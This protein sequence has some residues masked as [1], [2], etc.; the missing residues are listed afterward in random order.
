[1]KTPFS[2]SKLFG[3][4]PITDF[5]L[6]PL[7]L[8]FCFVDSMNSQPCDFYNPCRELTGPEFPDETTLCEQVTGFNPY[9]TIANGAYASTLHLTTWDASTTAFYGKDILIQGIFYIDQPT[10]FM[11]CR[12]K[13]AA[14]AQIVVL[15]QLFLTNEFLA[16]HCKFFSCDD[17]WKGIVLHYN[18]RCRLYSNRIEDAQYAITVYP[19]VYMA[20][21]GNTFNRNFVS[22]TNADGNHSLPLNLF[23]NNTFDCTSELSDYY[24][25]NFTCCVEDPV[26]FAGILLNNCSSKIGYYG[27]RNRFN[28]LNY[29]VFANNST[30]HINGCTFKD[31]Q[32]GTIIP[33]LI[34]EFPQEGSGIVG[35]NSNI[36]IIGAE[37]NTS[38]NFIDADLRALGSNLS[39]SFAEFEDCS[40]VADNN[41]VG[42]LVKIEDNKLNAVE[43]ESSIF[44]TR[45]AS[46]GG[47]IHT[48]IRRNI[49]D[50][51][52]G[53]GIGFPLYGIRLKGDYNPTDYALVDYNNISLQSRQDFYSIYFTVNK[54]E[55]TFIENN[56]IEFKG[57]DVDEGNGIFLEGGQTMGT[58]VAENTITG[59]ASSNFLSGI[60]VHNVQGMDIKDVRGIEY[61]QNTSDLLKNG[62][63]FRG[64]CDGSH[65]TKNI[66][67]EHDT[68][69]TISN[70]SGT[71]GVIGVQ[72]RTLNEWYGDSENG[73]Y[74]NKA[75]LYS[76]D[77]LLIGKSLYLLT[78]EAASSLV[79]NPTNV[80]PANGWFIPQPG[81]ENLC[82]A[83]PGPN[84]T[85]FDSLILTSNSLFE[86]LP[87]PVKFYL[88][89]NIIAK[90]LEDDDLIDDWSSYLSTIEEETEYLIAQ[91]EIEIKKALQ[92][93]LTDQGDLDDLLIQMQCLYDSIKVIDNY[94][95]THIDSTTFTLS[96]KADS[97]QS[98]LD[99]IW[100]LTDEQQT[101]QEFRMNDLISDFEDIGDNLDLITPRSSYDQYYVD[102]Y[103]LF[104]K[105][106]SFGGLEPS[107][108][109]DLNA[110]AQDYTDSSMANVT[111]FAAFELCSDNPYPDYTHECEDE[112][113]IEESQVNNVILNFDELIV[114]QIGSSEVSFVSNSPLTGIL[115]L[116]D[117]AGRC[118]YVNY[119]NEDMPEL[120]VKVNLIP[121]VYYYRLI[122]ID[123][124]L[125]Y[126]SGLIPLVR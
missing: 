104:I 109:D 31:A 98:K 96:T 47:G 17:M 24:D 110:I 27:S 124:K 57:E 103:K 62:F 23:K 121:G 93:N 102:I 84:I 122:S 6:F 78:N 66:I 76:G 90:I 107:D 48:F 100:S 12:I 75:A 91:V 112:P 67:K 111:A 105:E 1:M 13:L 36:F 119:L 38:C 94:N 85:P 114:R 9:Y 15:S 61:C 106:I 95:Y 118:V 32:H 63:R 83:S 89:K 2:F 3:I 29:G 70:L 97:L 108:Y 4:I 58:R 120:N 44:V 20:L 25:L 81:S 43:E 50:F 10:A 72:K 99:Q 55:N 74:P 28:N 41:L 19:K 42:Q 8:S 113:R 123:Y 37:E 54:S 88:E 11:N 39:I 77:P 51:G 69:L 117:L 87:D 71:P 35:L 49:I 82:H 14:G 59:I 34:E 7:L 125:L 26:S 22:I 80:L 115:S 30:A 64:N 68:G 21:Y 18:S 116:F 73:V 52:T 101:I 5:W 56:I 53:V 40:I 92:M 65:I 16:F 79:T 60:T 126:K 33:D 46:S 45:S 86:N